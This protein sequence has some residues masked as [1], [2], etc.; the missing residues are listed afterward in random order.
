MY[1]GGLELFLFV[2]GLDLLDK[3]RIYMLVCHERH[4]TS[5]R[6]DDDIIVDCSYVLHHIETKRSKP[7]VVNRI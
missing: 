4:K 2:S 1:L 7:R 6:A 5:Y 3:F